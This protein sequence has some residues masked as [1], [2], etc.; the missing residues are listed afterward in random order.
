[1][2]VARFVIVLLIGYR[3]SIVN[4]F[5][6]YPILHVG[7]SFYFS[8]TGWWLKFTRRTCWS[9]SQLYVGNCVWWWIH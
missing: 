1:M 3:G 8:A 2:A 7:Y 6:L 5:S 4:C 9:I